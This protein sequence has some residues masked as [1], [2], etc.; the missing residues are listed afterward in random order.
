MKLMLSILAAL[1]L[2]GAAA[3][4]L[5]AEAANGQRLA[6]RW[7]ASCHVVSPS[8]RQASAD[9]APFASIARIPQFSAHTLAFFLLAPHPKMPDMALSRR[10]AEDLAAYIVQSGR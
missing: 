7:C 4:G 5:A 10:E 8:Q 2:A 1:A 3:P 6:E 9:V